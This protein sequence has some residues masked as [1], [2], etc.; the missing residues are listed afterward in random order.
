MST[1]G[2][3]A[4]NERAARRYIESVE[5]RGG[6]TMLITP[7]GSPLNVSSVL[8]SIGGLMLTGG[9]DIDPSEY[10]EQPDPNAGLQLS[11]ERDA[12]EI[13][14]LREGLSRDIPIL[15]IC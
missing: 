12:I 13:P 5:K 15:A 2:I 11:K 9:E 10:N 8:N 1:I 6:S 3:I 7:D 4:S 14:L